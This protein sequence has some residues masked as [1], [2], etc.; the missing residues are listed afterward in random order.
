VIGALGPEP[1]QVGAAFARL[2][3]GDPEH[4]HEVL[5]RVGLG[6]VHRQPVPLD[7]ALQVTLVP[8]RGEDDRPLSLG[9]ELLEL[10]RR[11]DRVEE[12]QT[13]AVVDRV[14]RDVLVP[15]RTRL[16]FRMR[17]LPVPQAGCQLAHPS[18]VAGVSR[19]PRAPATV[20][21]QI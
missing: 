9:Y 19:Q 12:Q 7:E 10:A 14:R 18:I 13:L 5:C 11:R 3:G 15:R 16:P 1:D 17:C 2:L 6:R 21:R 4:P 20:S 8:R